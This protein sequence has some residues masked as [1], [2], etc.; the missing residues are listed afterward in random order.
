MIMIVNVRLSCGLIDAQAEKEKHGK[1]TSDQNSSF[2]CVARI[3]HIV[4]IVEQCIYM[5]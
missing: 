1:W 4:Y 2:M 5:Q 3:I